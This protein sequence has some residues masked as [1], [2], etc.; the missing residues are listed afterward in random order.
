MARK[1]ARKAPV[2]RRHVDLLLKL[3]DLRREEK[4]RKARQWFS[5]E[6]QAASPEESWQK[7]PPGSE[8]ERYIRMVL[9]YWDMVAVL[10]NRGAIE[11]DLFQETTGEHFLVWEKFKHLAPAIRAAFKNPTFLQNLEKLATRT[12]QWREKRA[13]GS[14]QA[15][16]QYIQQRARAAR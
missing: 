8:E 15:F 6:F 10:V 7:Y 3:Y 2:R 13:P 14:T 9:S 5:G 16:R 11:E 4:L 1:T 12:E